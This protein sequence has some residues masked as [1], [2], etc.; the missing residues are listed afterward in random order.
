MWWTSLAS[1]SV[2]SP[3]PSVVAIPGCQLGYIWN[4]LQ[5]RIGR[6]ACDTNIEAQRYTFLTWAWHGDLEAEWLWIPEELIQ[7]DL[8]VQGHLGLKVWW[9]TPLIWVT[10]SAGDYLRTLEEGRRKNHSSWPACLLGWS[11]CSILGLP[12]TAA[13]W[14]SVP[15]SLHPCQHLL[16]S[17]FLILAFLAGKR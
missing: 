13:R 5:S 7:G 3:C 14:R 6:L 4:Y 16:S 12:S 1:P 15:F 10:P 17:E 8:W 2:S 11:N 9:H